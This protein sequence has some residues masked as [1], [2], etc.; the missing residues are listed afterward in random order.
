M[1]LVE[2]H[3]MGWIPVAEGLNYQI[4]CNECC[5]EIPKKDWK[6]VDRRENERYWKLL[7]DV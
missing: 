1:L 5:N 4:E 2:L 3:L 7:F 6:E